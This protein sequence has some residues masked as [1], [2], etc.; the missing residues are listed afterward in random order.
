M[1]QYFTELYHRI[2]I[3]TEIEP[4]W[5]AVFSNYLPPQTRLTWLIFVGYS[6]MA[7]ASKTDTP[8]PAH[9]PHVCKIS[10]HD[11]QVVYAVW[12]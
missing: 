11:M 9:P 6:S 2:R 4:D 1:L 8:E 3:L 7:T 12:F 10:G 5:Y